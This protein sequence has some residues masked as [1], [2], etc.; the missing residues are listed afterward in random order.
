[1][2]LLVFMVAF[3][4]A[5]LHASVFLIGSAQNTLDNNAIFAGALLEV[6][7]LVSYAQAQFGVVIHYH[8]VVI[9]YR[10]VAIHHLHFAI[11]HQCVVIHHVYVVIVYP[12]IHMHI[13][14][15]KL[16]VARNTSSM[17]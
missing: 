9:V 1:M 10:C 4:G 5:L 7:F 14:T 15:V 12:C 13:T 8:Y 2:V 3:L 11:L 17:C 16:C 6:I